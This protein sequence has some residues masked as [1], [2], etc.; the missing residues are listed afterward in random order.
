MAVL[1]LAPTVL[2][3]LVFCAHLVRNGMGILVPFVLLSL[4]LLALRTPCVARC[5]QAAL[6]SIAL[7]WGLQIVLIAGRRI[8]DGE[9]WIRMAVIL[10]CVALFAVFSAVLFEARPL[11]RRYPRRALV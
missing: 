3:F 1:L 4:G 8:A 2:S 5:F 9:P 7:L 6:V 11:R 10:S